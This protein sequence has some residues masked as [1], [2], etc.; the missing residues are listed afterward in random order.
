MK[1]SDVCIRRPVLAIVLNL[2]L[3]MI[4][5]CCYFYL[6]TRFFPKFE[7]K[8]IYVSTSFPGA[9]ADLVETAVTNPLEAALSTVSGVEIMTSQSY[10]GSSNI[11]LKL[12][13]AANI[14]QV[15]NAIRNQISAAQGE[16]PSSVNAPTV[17]VGW[18][19]NEFMDIAFTDPNKT[20]LQIRDYIQRY[21]MNP[22]VQV[23]GIANAIVWGADKYAVRIQL[24][25]QAM[26][27]RHININMIQSAIENS[28]IEMPAG[29]IKSANL[30]F[31]VTAKT[32]F[33]SLDDFR[34]LMITNINNQA[35]R[36]KDIASINLGPATDD[37]SLLLINNQPGVALDL[38]VDDESSPITVAQYMKKTLD[39]IK[40]NLPQGMTM[41][42]FYDT[43]VFLKDAVHE[44]Y[45]SMCF[46]IVCVL[47]AVFL[48]LGN[49]RAI[50]I[51]IATIPVCLI[52]TFAIMFFLGFTINVI[53]LLAIVL[54]IGLVVDDAIVMLENI[55]R[56]LEQG[57]SSF[58]AALTG[59]KQIAFAIVGMTISLAAVYAPVGLLHT[60]I[61]VIF[62]EFAYTLA[63]AVLISGFVALT[64]SPM[65]CGRLLRQ[66]DLHG[67]Y[68]DWLE[69]FFES[70]RLRYKNVLTKVLVK[71]RSIVILTVLLAIV[72]GF[73]FK[74]IP[75]QFM[76]EEDMGF[77]YTVLDIPT[78][79][80]FNYIRNQAAMAESVLKNN[81]AVETIAANISDAP[82]SYNNLFVVLKPFSKRHQSAKEIAQTINAQLNKIPGLNAFVFAPS[83]FSGSS[84]Q[85][86][87][88]TL[89]TSGSYQS[90]YYTI[91]KLKK[92]LANYP[93]VSNINSDMEFNSQ[94]YNI[95]VNREL[96]SS[97]GISIRDIDSTLAAFL[98]GTTVTRYNLDN[99][100]YDVILEADENF[101]RN[102]DDMNKFY[103]V[104]NNNTLVPLGNLIDVQP[105]LGEETLPHYN[106]L[107]SANINAQLGDGYAMG[108][109]MNYLD[110][111]LSDMLPE[112]TKFA[113]TGLAKNLQENNASML[114][115]FGLALV[116]IYLI[117]AGL[118]ESFIDP[119][120]V[121][122]TVPVCI[123]GALVALKLFGG[124]LNIY[125]DIGLITLIGLVSKH[126][127]LMTQFINEIRA[128]GKELTP[129]IL[130]GA[131]IRLRPILMTTTAMIFGALPLVFASGASAVS[132]QQ[133]GIVIISGLL[134]G[135][136]FS[137]FVVPVAYSYLGKKIKSKK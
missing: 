40:A 102:L 8:S 13:P 108:E 4:G 123:V 129:A 51:P 35:V 107:R 72:G 65:M 79:A 122:L 116:F 95:S 84:H 83:P 2:I 97:L 64:L 127:I 33:K 125:T 14:D 112:E 75:S 43:S 126:G 114:I 137:L 22:V 117:L 136:L 11:T 109:V 69:N 128:E 99:Y 25:P 60:R 130:E 59:S 71:R 81:P 62:C 94:Q 45:F 67:R 44:V 28:N 73:V 91:Q 53:T 76:P 50:S 111:H 17:Q 100:S 20:P 6:E 7:P 58:Q 12:Q 119:C 89:M 30:N 87:Q 29:R 26:A 10:R 96:A 134:I 121:L 70:L 113:F 110:S 15:A 88:F 41:T 49:W 132:R 82:D 92:S 3:V 18:S 115:I 34:D 106:R 19:Q 9:S 78:G 133:I 39:M 21:V 54:S 57:M 93:G 124:S 135:T 85:D 66:Q 48:F 131:S 46:A 118:F 63:G 105:A 16:L 74:S 104:D 103:L 120:I 80:S 61:A 36:L 37:Q 32:A 38:Y 5:I 42:L 52:S 98:G 27:A 77:I 24:D 31:P 101:L 47:I 55:H 56:Y 68:V 1:L 86:L 90:L 23:P